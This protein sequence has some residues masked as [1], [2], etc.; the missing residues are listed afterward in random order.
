[1]YSSMK[2]GFLLSDDQKVKRNK[3]AIKPKPKPT[4]L[5]KPSTIASKI[6]VPS[7]YLVCET[8]TI[9]YGT[10]PEDPQRIVTDIPDRSHTSFSCA[11]LFP[12]MKEAIFS[13]PGFPEPLRQTKAHHIRLVDDSGI[14]LG[15]FAD[16]DLDTG[17]MIACERPLIVRPIYLDSANAYDMVALTVERLPPD[18]KKAFWELRNVKGDDRPP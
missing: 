10:M 13:I 7:G 4:P 12:G 9:N 15:M 6:I 18:M 17:D 1:M 5:E 16:E 8:N 11:L 14:G 3:P 2:R